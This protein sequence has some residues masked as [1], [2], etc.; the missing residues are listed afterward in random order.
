MQLDLNPTILEN[1]R[2]NLTITAGISR[3]AVLN[4]VIDF[5]NMLIFSDGV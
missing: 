4:P 2:G 1:A 5:R 3:R